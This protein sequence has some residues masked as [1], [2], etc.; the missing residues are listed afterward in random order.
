MRAM[1]ARA[2][3]SV[4]RPVSEVARGPGGHWLAGC[5]GNPKG[6]LRSEHDLPELCREHTKEAVERLIQIMRADDDGRALG[7][8][9]ILLDRG[10]GKPL[11]R[12][13]DETAPESLSMLHLIAARRVSELLQ[14]Q[15]EA[16]TTNPNGP[17]TTPER[18]TIDWNEPALE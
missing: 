11:Q 10:W 9:Q 5:S 8:I 7:A 14:A 16:Q 4:P 1:R 2:R 3:D 12:L 13:V 18:L 15:F 6:R 17:A